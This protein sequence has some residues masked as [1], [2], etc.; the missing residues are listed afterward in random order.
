MFWVIF[1]LSLYTSCFS[2]I[3]DFIEL[4]WCIE[5]IALVWL[6]RIFAL[7]R[8][9]TCKDGLLVCCLVLLHH[10][11]LSLF[12]PFFCP[13]CF[14]YLCLVFLTGWGRSVLRHSASSAL[15]SS[16]L[17]LP[18]FLVVGASCCGLLGVEDL[19]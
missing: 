10:R 6:K 5:T 11:A 9:C 3:A 18:H 8:Y 17:V 19:C 1:T 7:L 14:V 16:P 2:F 4:S 15:S 13:L 12:L